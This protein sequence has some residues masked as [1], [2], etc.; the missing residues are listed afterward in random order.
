MVGFGNQ[1][2][3]DGQGRLFVFEKNSRQISKGCFQGFCDS[4]HFFLAA[5]RESFF[6]DSGGIPDFQ[7]VIPHIGDA[8]HPDQAIKILQRISR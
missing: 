5:G 4:G 8:R 6:V 7:T 1:P 3:M 2:V